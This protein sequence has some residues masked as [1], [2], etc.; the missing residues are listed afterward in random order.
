M[1][2]FLSSPHSRQYCIQ[3]EQGKVPKATRKK[4]DAYW[5]AAA[6][7]SWLVSIVRFRTIRPLEM[8]LFDGFASLGKFD[9]AQGILKVVLFRATPAILSK[10]NQSES[11]DD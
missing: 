11:T 7:P 1:E 3:Q 5:P 2:I 9:R 6:Q 10:P 4:G 8:A